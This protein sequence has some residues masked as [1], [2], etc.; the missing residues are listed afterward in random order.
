[1]L[2]AFVSLRDFTLQ[3]TSDYRPSE[4]YI[5]KVSRQAPHLEYFTIRHGIDHAFRCK[6]VNKN[7]VV[8]DEDE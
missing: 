2:V 5:T 7:W 6:R 1:M 3:L 4:Q 8:C